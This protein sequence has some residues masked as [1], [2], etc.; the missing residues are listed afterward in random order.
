MIVFPSDHPVI[1]NVNSYYVDIRKMFEHYQGELPAGVFHLKAPGVEG[2]I[3]FDENEAVNSIFQ[4]RETV[5]SGREAFERLLAAGAENNFIIGVYEIALEKV[6]FW[7]NLS[8]SKTIHTNL[9]TEFTDLEGL[10]KKMSSE[11]FNGYIDVSISGGSETAVILFEAGH[12]LDVSCSWIGDG[13]GGSEERLELIIQKTRQS[14]GVLNVSEVD[15][16]GKT[17][18]TEPASSP[19][20]GDGREYPML[21]ELLLIAENTIHSRKGHKV[22]FNTLFRKKCIANV[23]RYDFLDP[24]MAEFEYTG[25]RI[26]FS[27]GADDSRLAEGVVACVAEIAKDL[28]MAEDFRTATASWRSK[29]EDPLSRIDVHLLP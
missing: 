11:K 22:D 6:F 28:G 7:A 21:E 1:E 27:G 25:G 13:H 18:K 4:D 17:G 15:I 29:W 26:V 23:D 10:V 16:P 19:A 9:G 14:S 2:V 3:F 24:F 5:Y 12:I 8:K 20:R